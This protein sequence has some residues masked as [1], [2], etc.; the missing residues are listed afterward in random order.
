MQNKQ[1]EEKTQNVKIR[2]TP[3]FMVL[4]PPIP[5]KHPTIRSLSI[6]Y[7]PKT[8]QEA[9][10]PS[11]RPSIHPPTHYLFSHGANG[12]LNQLHQMQKSRVYRLIWTN[13]EV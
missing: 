10:Y 5:Y 4:V 2:N 3:I 7:L 11:I 8:K 13:W 1:E 9:F 12:R 6:Q